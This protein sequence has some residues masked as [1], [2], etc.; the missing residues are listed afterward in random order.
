MNKREFLKWIA[1]AGVAAGTASLTVGR[2]SSDPSTVQ[3]EDSVFDRV[4]EQ[5]E[6]RVGYV[7]YHP[8]L[9]KDPNTGKLKGFYYDIIEAIGA[10]LNLKINWQEE[11]SF[12]N[13]IEGL[14]TNRYDIVGLGVF[15]SGLRARGADFSEATHFES[16]HALVRK[17]N[18]TLTSLS[19][20]NNPH[21]TASVIEGEI[22]DVVARTDFPQMKLKAVSNT[23]EITQTLEDV[24]YK[25]ADVAFAPYTLAKKYL[26]QNPGKLKLLSPGVP[27]RVFKVS[28]IFKRDEENFK[29]LINT[30]LSQ[31]HLLGSID[32]ALKKYE[33]FPN[34]FYRVAQPYAMVTGN[35]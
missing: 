35:S 26:H 24:F 22:A 23:V 28:L 16:L 5:G 14:N 7:L 8:H 6:I 15:E 11:V 29:S 34:S 3:T 1:T 30:A 4:M 13:M 9:F 27:V 18:N 32:E 25:K 17:D 2:S 10:Q 33:E 12:A 31:L 20:L 19:Q 21:I